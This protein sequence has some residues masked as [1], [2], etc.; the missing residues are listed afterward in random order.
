MLAEFGIQVL[1]LIRISIGPLALGNLPKG[2]CRQL[3]S[4]EIQ[5]LDR[6]MNR[7]GVVQKN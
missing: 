2:S 3:T 6:A 4:E 5:A 7:I 1:R